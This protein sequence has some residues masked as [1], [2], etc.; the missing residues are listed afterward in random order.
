MSLVM[1]KKTV[2]SKDIDDENL[3]LLF[4][5][6]KNGDQYAFKLIID[7]VTP[8]IRPLIS[9]L[10]WN[11]ADAEDI[12]Q[13]VALQLYISLPRF[14]GDCKMTS[15][16][17]RVTI[18][19]CMNSQ[20]RLARNP[21]NFIDLPTSTGDESFN[22]FY[23]SQRHYT[24]EE[25]CLRSEREALIHSFILRISP[26]YRVILVLSDINKMNQQE[27]A[28]ILHL[29]LGTV[30]SRQKRARDQMKQLILA[31]RELFY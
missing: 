30:K 3:T 28:D 17:Y 21:L 27:I 18:N 8:M 23:P 6:F 19:I 24:P 31:N 12:L 16:I 10:V 1:E 5:R 2:E 9:R 25:S 4:H 20:K 26:K 13:D 29:P 15:F 14:R 7:A 22:A 11:F